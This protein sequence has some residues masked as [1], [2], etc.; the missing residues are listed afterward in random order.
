MNFSRILDIREEK[1]LTQKELASIL[2][3]TRVSIS[4]WEN[5]K[6]IPNIRKINKMANHFNVSLDY[7]FHLSNIKNY[8]DIIY[9]DIDKTVVGKRIL[10]VRNE[11]NLT[12]RSLAKQLNTT[13]STICG[14]EQGKTLLLTAFA[15]EICKRYH[16]SMD[17]LYGKRENKN[18]K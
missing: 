16:V 7:I 12:L 10:T 15:I 1:E 13:S 18:L 9:K 11:N 8:P 6:E 4:K 2:G 3:G 17:W 14:Y 5:E